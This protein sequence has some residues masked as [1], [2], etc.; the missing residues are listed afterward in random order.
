MT[1]SDE[2]SSDCY[3]LH[4]AGHAYLYR[5]QRRWWRSERTLLTNTPAESQPHSGCLSR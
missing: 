3:R 5:Y 2:A 4:P 1:D